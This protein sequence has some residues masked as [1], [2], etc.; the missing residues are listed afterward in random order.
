MH[1]TK[2][3]K[4][5]VSCCVFK[6]NFVLNNCICIVSITEFVISYKGVRWD[7]KSRSS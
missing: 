7:L 6:G 1:D 5:G 4:Y 3:V 2:A